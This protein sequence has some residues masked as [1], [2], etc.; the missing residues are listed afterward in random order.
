[1]LGQDNLCSYMLFKTVKT[2]LPAAVLSCKSDREGAVLVSWHLW[3]SVG[4]E[5]EINV[6]ALGRHGL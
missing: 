6:G 2:S 4:V 5:S 1:M 3:F